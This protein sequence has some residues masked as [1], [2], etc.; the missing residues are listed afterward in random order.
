MNRRAGSGRGLDHLIDHYIVV[1]IFMALFIL[2]WVGVGDVAVVG[3]L[4]L[5]LCVAGCSRESAQ[6]DLWVLVSLIGY[7]LASMASSY[8]AYGNITDGYA[9]MHMIFPVLYLLMACLERQELMLLR[10]LCAV[11]AGVTAAAGILQFVFHAV[12]Q[13]TAARLGGF[14][15]NPNAM[16]IFLVL[17]WF[18]LMG[19]LEDAETAEGGKGSRHVN[20]IIALLSMEPIL[21]IALALTLSMGSFVAMAA[22]IL[23][24]LL[25][26]IFGKG[27]RLSLREAAGSACRILARASLGVGTGML[28]YLAAARTS[29]P[30]VCLPLLLYVLAVMVLWKKYSLFLEVYP[31]MAAV[32]SG[33]GLLVAAAAVFVRP[34]SLATFSE[35]LEMIRNGIGYLTVHPLFGVGPYQWRMLNLYDGDTYFNT[36]HIH[37]VPI[38]VGVEFGWIAMVM[39]LAVAAGFFRKKAEPW[40]KAGFTAFCVH[41]MMDTGFF[42][43]GIT[44][45]AMTAFGDPGERG[46]KLGRRALRIFY[47]VSAVLFA[48]HIGYYV[49][50]I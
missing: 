9:S 13:G 37:N 41:N 16:G 2:T 40:R 36:W 30:W 33:F 45:L 49:M 32:L 43:L 23:T 18:A 34:S 44:T 47:G 27:G 17:G 31:K 15:G 38:H 1:C 11:W 22:G 21:L 6:V 28:L 20:Q 26:R 46:R 14:L 29:V 19:C 24:L 7:D 48:Y 39:L 25:I 35:R 4:G 8:A 12:V 42:Y 10:Q 3:I 50:H 5:I